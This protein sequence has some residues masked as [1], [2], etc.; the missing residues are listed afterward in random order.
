MMVDSEDTTQI[1]SSNMVNYT[2]RSVTWLNRS[3]I[4]H[5]YVDMSGLHNYYINLYSIEHSVSDT[6]FVQI[7]IHLFE[8]NTDK[9]TRPG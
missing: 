5:N 8:C 2:I 4:T 1:S 3:L 7:I 9:V 6:T